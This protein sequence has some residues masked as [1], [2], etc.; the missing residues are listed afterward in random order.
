[1]RTLLASWVLLLICHV[2][3]HQTASTKRNTHLRKRQGLNDLFKMMEAMADAFGGMADNMT[4]N[5][6]A[7]PTEVPETNFVPVG[8]FEH[9]TC[10]DG[11]IPG[12]DNQCY[13][14]PA[15]PTS[16]KGT[17]YHVADKCT[18]LGPFMHLA[19]IRSPEEQKFVEGILSAYPETDFWIGGYQLQS[20]TTN[21]FKWEEDRTHDARAHPYTNWDEGQPQWENFIGP[22]EC[23]FLGHKSSFN[24]K[25]HDHRC[26]YDGASY[27][28]KYHS[29]P[30]PGDVETGSGSGP[31]DEDDYAYPY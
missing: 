28:C 2:E 22:E 27:I 24:L 16:D 14:V 6:V 25:W 13:F 29:I 23:I 18:D 10:F 12:P 19:S 1:M 9:E 7:E 5:E 30:S 20:G 4:P 31:D 3:L 26:S 17:F 21:V 11:W 15:D 8:G